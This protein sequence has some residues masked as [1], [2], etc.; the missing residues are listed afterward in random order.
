MLVWT[1]PT[2]PMRKYINTKSIKVWAQTPVFAMKGITLVLWKD[3]KLSL[4][5]H[6]CSVNR[7]GMF[8]LCFVL[9]NSL[10]SI[11]TF[12]KRPHTLLVSVTDKALQ[13]WSRDDLSWQR[14][15]LY[16]KLQ[17]EVWN[18]VC[19]LYCWHSPWFWQLTQGN[20]F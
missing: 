6:F 12:L 15:M 14:C 17:T 4:V 18:V 16:G 8:L 11:D 19:P 9:F 20:Y 5:S 1:S 10:L 2:F 7:R 13:L 3:K